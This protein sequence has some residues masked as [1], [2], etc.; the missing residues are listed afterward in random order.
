MVL[1]DVGVLG[2]SGCVQNSQEAPLQGVGQH[3]L[4]VQPQDLEAKTCGT[5]WMINLSY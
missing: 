5:S 1:S 2:G 4:G 3:Q